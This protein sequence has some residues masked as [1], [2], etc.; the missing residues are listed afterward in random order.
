VGGRGGRWQV[1]GNRQHG[2]NYI[3]AVKPRVDL[4][5]TESYFTSHFRLPNRLFILYYLLICPFK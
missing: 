2:P 1:A 5:E 4:E 3:R